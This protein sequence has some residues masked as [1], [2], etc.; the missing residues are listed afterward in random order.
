[1]RRADSAPRL[2]VFVGPRLQDLA[3]A[4]S[5]VSGEKIASA[6]SIEAAQLRLETTRLGPKLKPTRVLLVVE[7]DAA[8][9]GLGAALR[10]LVTPLEELL[11]P[12]VRTVIV[13]EARIC[14]FGMVADL[15]WSHVVDFLPQELDQRTAT[16]RLLGAWGKRSLRTAT[17]GMG[18]N[19]GAPQHVLTHLATQLSATIEPLRLK[20]L[21]EEGLFQASLGADGRSWDQEFE[22]KMLREFERRWRAS[23]WK[24]KY[25]ITE[26]SMSYLVAKGM[27][28]PHGRAL[29]PR[30]W[31]AYLAEVVSGIADM[32]E[33]DRR[34]LAEFLEGARRDYFYRGSG[35]E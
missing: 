1:M 3:A 15:L 11:F 17:L 26:D 35:H 9:D 12:D 14:D 20:R 13:G 18:L 28:D 6:Q 16:Q 19:T 8:S 4:Y 23:G 29:A 31:A 21:S 22:Q 34:E 10:T 24:E 33:K 2:A 25:S 30:L 27:S 7:S 32:T 5:G